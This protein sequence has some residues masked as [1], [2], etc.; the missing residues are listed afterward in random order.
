MCAP[1]WTGPVRSPCRPIARVIH[2]L[3][4]QFILDEQPGIHD[5]VGMVGNRLEVNLHIIYL[6]RR[7]RHK[8]LSPALTRLGLE[9]KDTRF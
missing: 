3:P 8:A 7:A 1:Q 2:L 4:Q 5:P 6:R 9:V